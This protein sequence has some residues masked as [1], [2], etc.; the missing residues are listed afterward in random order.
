[1]EQLKE[2]LIEAQMWAF[3]WFLIN[4]WIAKTAERPQIPQTLIWISQSAQSSTDKAFQFKP[5]KRHMAQVEPTYSH[6][7]T[8]FM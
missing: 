8:C 3:V 5:L 2:I 4:Q 1:M 7:S 6:K